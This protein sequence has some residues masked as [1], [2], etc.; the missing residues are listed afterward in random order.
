V[1]LPGRRVNGWRARSR[2]TSV[3]IDL[4]WSRA[5]GPDYRVRPVRR[6][7]RPESRETAATAVF[8]PGP[9]PHQ[10]AARSPAVHREVP[11]AGRL[12]R[13]AASTTCPD[14]VL[15]PLKP[16]VTAVFGGLSATSQLSELWC[17]S[18]M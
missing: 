14:V 1:G 15:G 13:A 12:A 17:N 4:P 16:S 5:P 18:Y 7:D 8:T 10:P 2:M 6:R 3:E 9:V 11:F